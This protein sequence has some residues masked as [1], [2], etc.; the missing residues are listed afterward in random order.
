RRAWEAWWR[1][2]GDRLDPGKRPENW[3]RPILLV[4]CELGQGWAQGRVWLCGCDGKARCEWTGL[5]KPTEARLVA[6]PRVLI[7]EAPSLFPDD[8]SWPFNVGDRGGRVTERD[9]VGRVWWEYREV[10]DPV[11]C[12]RLSN[13]NTFIA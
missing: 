8:R 10:R 9:A 2:H 3:R 13:G 1:D 5:C 11:E 7:A 12:R 4:L 6:G